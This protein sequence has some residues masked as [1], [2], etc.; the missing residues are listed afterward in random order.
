[1]TLKAPNMPSLT[2]VT[3][4]TVE[5]HPLRQTKVF[6]IKT[7]GVDCG[8]QVAAWISQY[9]GK[10]GDASAHA[11][12]HMGMRVHCPKPYHITLQ[13]DPFHVNICFLL[14]VID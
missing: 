1:M 9:L 11:L 3:P 7:S 12:K 6:G 13:R 2:F 4:L 14:Q 10:E 8:D 5:A